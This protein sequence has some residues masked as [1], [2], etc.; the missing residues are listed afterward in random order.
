MISPSNDRFSLKTLASGL[1]QI[2][3]PNICWLCRQP[4]GPEER[5][6]CKACGEQV[7]S[8]PRPSCPRCAA[9][10]GPFGVVDSGCPTCTS[11]QFA[12]DAAHRLGPYDGKLREVILR[13][14]NA[15]A[16][17]L[18]EIVAEEWAARVVVKLRPMGI[19]AVLPVPLHW[20]RRWQRGVNQSDALARAFAKTL[21]VPWHPYGLRRLR[22]TQ[23][24]THLSPS[25]RRDNV[26]GAFECRPALKLAGYTVLLVDDVMTT[27]STSHEAARALRRAGAARVIVAVLA[28]AESPK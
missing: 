5:G 27:G 17:G 14:K 22:K 20:W 6:L 3:Y 15:N 4:M 12:F 21:H 1:L 2:F 9:T 16:E 13:I 23:M 10:V 8:D 11:E 26:R 18:A 19:Q 7:Y 28:R 25:A 24:Q